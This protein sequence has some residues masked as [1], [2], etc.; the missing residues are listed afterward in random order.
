V[1]RRDSLLRALRRD[2]VATVELGVG[3]VT[4]NVT[5]RSDDWVRRVVDSQGGHSPKCA[6]DQLALR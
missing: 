2:T 3:R 5:R 1:S 4:G 6:G